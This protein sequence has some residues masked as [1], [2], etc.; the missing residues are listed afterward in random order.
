M[1]ELKLGLVG[2]GKIARD[3]HLPALERNPS[4]ELC[5]IASPSSTQD[6]LPQF[7]SMEAML[8][9]MPELQA[10]ALCVPPAVRYQLASEALARGLHVL[11]EKP[12]GATLHEVELLSRQAEAAGVTLFATW[13]SRFA[14]A[15]G[16]ARE[17]LAG[18]TVRHVDVHWKE[19]VRVWHPGQ[20]W[21][22][23][24]G[25]MGVFDPG[26][27]GLSIVTAVLDHPFVLRD[28]RLHVPE[29]CQTPIA[30]D[31]VFQA[32]GDTEMHA[33]FDFRQ[34]GPQ[35]WDIHVHTDDGK[36]TL[37]AGGS[38]MWVDGELIFEAPE[39]EYE[40]IYERF[41]ALVADN[42][43]DVDVT[44][45]RL[46]SDAFLLGRREHVEAFIE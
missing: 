39:R 34:T 8:D 11:L 46:V 14:P 15:V 17:W 40:G 19:D 9:A 28:A 26:I 44:P 22:W 33:A 41:A 45:L 4:M 38:Q 27:N 2:F 18:R 30:A 13:H 23:E 32:G 29:N 5:A 16:P 12:P 35:L 21:I 43:S 6:A 37:S 25:G 36:L 31:L 1:T 10:V 24:P 42:R 7:Q 20:D 3:Q